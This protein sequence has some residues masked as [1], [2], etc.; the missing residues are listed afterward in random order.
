MIEF[1]SY[2]FLCKIQLFTDFIDLVFVV[3]YVV[4][5]SLTFKRSTKSNQRDLIEVKVRQGETGSAG[6]IKSGLVVRNC[7]P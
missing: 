4:Y 2:K 1:S 6:C 3:S 5:C 7:H